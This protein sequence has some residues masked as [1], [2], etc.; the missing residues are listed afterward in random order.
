MSE[1]GER[2]GEEDSVAHGQLC[3][4]VMTP[5][6]AQQPVAGDD[7]V[8]R[9]VAADAMQLGRDGILERLF[10]GRVLNGNDAVGEVPGPDTRPAAAPDT[11]RR[12]RRSASGRGS[13]RTTTGGTS[14]GTVA[15]G[16]SPGTR[17]RPTRPHNSPT[18]PAPSPG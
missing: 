3:A 8:G 16:P 12:G 1:I 15:S 2:G 14:A 17:S 13:S 10:L 6:A 9:Q 7:L 18:R 5:V 4:A 11:P